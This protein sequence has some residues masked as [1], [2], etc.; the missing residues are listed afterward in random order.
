M[1]EYPLTD[2]S[3]YPVWSQTT[4][5]YSDLDPNGHV[6]NGAF[7]AYFEDGRVRLRTQRLAEV[8][9][10]MLT[11]FAIAKITIEYRAPLAFPATVDIGSSIVRIG[12]SSYTLGQAVFEG[13]RCVATAEV[14]TV[15]FDPATHRSMPIE[16]ELR[17][18][19]QTLA[20]QTR[21]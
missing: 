4:V 16:D 8:G 2:R 17:A 3:I 15:R 7:S 11:G 12:R 6:N 5:R 21:S 13:D 10:A 19:L 9:G 18:V 1:S 14:V 20:P